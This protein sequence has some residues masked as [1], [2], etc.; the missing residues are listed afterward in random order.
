MERRLKGRAATM[1]RP[2]GGHAGLDD[3]HRTRRAASSFKY[4]HF[5][6]HRKLHADLSRQKACIRSGISGRQDQKHGAGLRCGARR[7]GDRRSARCQEQAP[8][9][10]NSPQRARLG[11]YH[12]DP[13]IG[14]APAMNSSGNPVVETVNADGVSAAF[15]NVVT[16]STVVA[17]L[18]N[19]QPAG[20]RQ[21]RRL[22]QLAAGSVY[23]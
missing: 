19:G 4:K 1:R 7:Y 18:C 16:F 9:P 8:V 15:N 2:H 3:A 20:R 5:R 13:V 22:R 11:L 21:R 23:Q 10:W 6:E 14:L 17:Y 12:I